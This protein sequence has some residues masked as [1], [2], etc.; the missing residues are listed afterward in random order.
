MQT[1]DYF[2]AHGKL[3][4]TGE[5]LV[6][7]G[8]PALAIPTQKGQWLQVSS[9]VSNPPIIHWHSFRF[10]HS[11]WFDAQ[12]DPINWEIRQTSQGDVAQ[13]LV[14]LLKAIQNLQPQAFKSDRSLHFK[15]HL[16]FPNEWGLGTSST[17][18]TNLAKWARINPYM[19]LENSFGGSGYDIACATATGPI[20]YRRNG[21]Q[22]IVK[23]IT[24]HPPFAYQLAFLY[25]GQKQNSREGIARYREKKQN[26]PL[27]TLITELEQLNQQWLAVTQLEEFEKVL[28]EHE[29][30]IA[31]IIELPTLRDSLFPDYEGQLKSLGAWGG[32]F[33]LVTA[34]NGIAEAQKYFQ[35]K[36]L[37]VFIPFEEMI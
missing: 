1:I 11:L 12:I 16:E 4:L 5:Y 34:P 25:L 33:A 31:S 3:L 30:L 24:F 13:R 6:L 21:Y 20:Q 19:L 28:R 37:S 32:D 2:Y 15:T 29:A 10:D 18:I 9:Q 27:P 26:L 23:S 36:G 22:P 7:D 17:L 14:D 8:A 35:S